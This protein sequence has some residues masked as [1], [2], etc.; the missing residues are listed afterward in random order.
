MNVLVIEDEP[1]AR[2]RLIRMLALVAPDIRVAEEADSAASALRTLERYQPEAI[3]TD[4]QLGDGTCFDVF[5]KNNPRCPVVFITAFDEHALEAFRV[6]AV[7]YLLKPLRQED[8]T[9]A[10]TRLRERSVKPVSDFNALASQLTAANPVGPARFLIRYGDQL[11][12]ITEQDIAYMYTI[13]KAVFFVLENG[14]EYPADQSLDSLETVLDPVRFFR[15]NR[16][17]IISRHAIGPM[18]T[19][20]KSRV[21]LELTPPFSHG[22][23]IV[24]T[25]KSPHF[26]AW[27]GKR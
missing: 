10:C 16:Q 18:Q 8:L 19:T 25:E 5:A 21:I 11:R 26:K 7:D 6:H 3:F 15:I 12:H 14:R 20:T 22:E 23:V 27:L 9:R 1:I 4:I 24:S 17:F 2:K 13:H